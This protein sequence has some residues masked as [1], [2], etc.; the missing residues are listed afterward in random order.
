MR[1]AWDGPEGE[2]LCARCAR[3]HEPAMAGA[4]LIRGQTS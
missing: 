3:E 2:I 4:P 1:D